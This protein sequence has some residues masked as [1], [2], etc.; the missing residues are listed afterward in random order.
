MVARVPVALQITAA[1]AGGRAAEQVVVGVTLPAGVSMVGTTVSVAGMGLVH[2]GASPDV[3]CGSPEPQAGGASLVTCGLG[4]LDAGASLPIALTVVAA[5]GGSYAFGVA[6]WARGVDP[7]RQTFEPTPVSYFGPQVRI[8]QVGD[9]HV[10]NP[11]ESRMD[12]PIRNAGDRPAHDVSVTFSMPAGLSVASRDEWSCVGGATVTCT[13][14]ADLVIPAGGRRTLHLDVVADGTARGGESRVRMSVD[15]SDDRDGAS[16][17]V[18]VTIEA[19]WVGLDDA[20][21]S[22]TTPYRRSPASPRPGTM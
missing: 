1:N 21:P 3:V 17:I 5:A 20:A 10:A 13:A 2:L 7:V 16:R 19:P 22:Q 11:G 14:P 6:V 12:I 8:D 15:A 9:V 18:A 4:T